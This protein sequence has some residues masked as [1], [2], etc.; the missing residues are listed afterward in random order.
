M[1]VILYPILIIAFIYAALVGL[2]AYNQRSFIFPAP[3]GPGVEVPGFE[4]IQYQTED[5]LTLTSG[6]RAAKE[7]KPTIL[8]FHGNGADW[9]SSVVA[10]DQLVPAGYGVLA[11]EYRGYRGNPGSPSEEGL[12]ADARAAAK[13]LG[14]QGVASDQVVI[15]GNS[16]GGGAATQLATEINPRALVLIST[17]TSLP[18]VAAEKIWWAPTRILL[19]DEFA[20]I[21]KIGEVTAP[22]LL[23]HGDADTLIHDGHSHALAKANPAATLRIVEGAGH[24]L[25]WMPEAEVAVLSFLQKLDAAK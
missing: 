24:D 8:Y 23:L 4:R 9:Q 20:N 7:G 14:E 1:N 11:A 2:M 6:Y 18:D 10:T 15:I 16:I 25:A 17:F 22:I 5:G 19:Q 13:W 21:D 12:Y 3:T